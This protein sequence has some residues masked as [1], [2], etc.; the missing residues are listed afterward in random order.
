MVLE[1][2][3]PTGRAMILMEIAKHRV[4]QD[5]K[6]GAQLGVPVVREDISYGISE[7]AQRAAC[8]RAS[9]EGKMSH[10]AI[11]LEELAE[12]VHAKDAAA[13]REEL[14][15]TAACLVKAIE[16]VDYQAARMGVTREV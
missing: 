11:I 2:S 16:A 10:M 9:R 13:M 4:E 8:E 6:H 12:V 3:V 15:Q 14:V 7:R 1:G 5:E